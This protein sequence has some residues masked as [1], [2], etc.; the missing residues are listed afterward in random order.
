VIALDPKNPTTV[1]MGTPGGEN[2][3]LKSTDG[4]TTWHPASSGLPQQRFKDRVHP[5][6]WLTFTVGVTALAID[7]AHPET[8]YAAT[9]WRGVFRSTDSGK[10]WHPFNAG[11][12]NHNVTALALDATGQTLYAGTAGGGVVSL[13]RNP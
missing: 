13:R 4:G 2:G 6:K 12:T 8:L 11:L 5:G 3:V 1:Y 10:N 7:P 9:G